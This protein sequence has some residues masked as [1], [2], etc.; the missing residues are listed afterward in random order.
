MQESNKV[1][2]I[3]G[4]LQELYFSVDNFITIGS[5]VA[6]FCALRGVNPTAGRPLG[7][8]AAGRLYPGSAPG[9]LPVCRRMYNVF[10]PFDP[11]AVRLAVV[12]SGLYKGVLCPMQAS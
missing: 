2:Q 5:P 6:L 8:P 10:H 12:P 11:V 1:E 9:A 3:T 7:S 4:R